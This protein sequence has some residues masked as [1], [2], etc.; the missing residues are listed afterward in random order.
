MD[1]VISNRKNVN[2]GYRN[3]DNNLY[4]FFSKIRY[5]QLLVNALQNDEKL[6]RILS[7]MCGL[8]QIIVGPDRGGDGSG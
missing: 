3:I 4:F 5:F 2:I 8:L 6:L 1:K 7:I